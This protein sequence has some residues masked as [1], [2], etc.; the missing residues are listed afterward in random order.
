MIAYDSTDN[1]LMA[2]IDGSWLM[3]EEGGMVDISDDTNITAGFGITITGDTVSV[4]DLYVQTAGDTMTG[5][6]NVDSQMVIGSTDSPEASIIL[7]LSANDQALRVTRL[8]DPVTDITQPRN[9]MIAYDSTDN[10]LMAYIDGS[11]L[12]LEEGGMVDISDDTNIMPGFGITI[13]GDTI[14]VTDLY[15]Q[16]AGDTMT[17]NL[18]V[19]SQLVVGGTLS[20]E[21]S[22]I[23]DLTDSNQALRVTRLSDPVTDIAQPRNGMIAYDSTDNELMAY[24]DGTWLMLEEG[25]MV[26]I[27]DDTNLT[28]DSEL[29]LLVTRSV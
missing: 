13:T 1:E 23:L 18:N 25:G 24:I 27:S 17:G 26:D 21:P 3:L 9:G 28:A 2:Y 10:E 19:A 16:T 15:V 11:W 12:M 6:L 8:S 20:P 4:T 22:I 5:N 29:Q 7:D 14:S